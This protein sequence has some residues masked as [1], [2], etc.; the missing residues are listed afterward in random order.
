MPLEATQ[1]SAE[2]LAAGRCKMAF[3]AF[4][5]RKDNTAEKGG[6]KLEHVVGFL[7]LLA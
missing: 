7:F 1:C 2:E 6:R 3:K 5:L 4:D